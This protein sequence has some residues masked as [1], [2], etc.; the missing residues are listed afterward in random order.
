MASPARDSVM[1]RA[2]PLYVALLLALLTAVGL[3]ALARLEHVLLILFISV[4]F[5]AALSGPTER[6]EKVRIPRAVAVPLIY[7]TAL[8]VAVAIVWLVTPP[9][10]SEVSEFGEAAP[11]YVERYEAVRD[12]YEELRERYP[13]IGPFDQRVA[14]L[15]EAIVDRASDRAFQLPAALFALF[16]DLLSI[17]VISTLLVSNRERILAAILELV[18]P[19][20]RPK[21]RAVLVAMWTRIGFYL[22]AKVIV[23][24][25]VGALTYGVLLVIGVPF[26]LPLAIVVALGEAIPRAGPWLARIPLLAIAALEG[27]GTLGITFVASVVIENLKGYVISPVVEGDQLDIH[28]LVVFVSVLV[29]GALLGVAGAFIAVPAAAMVQVLYEEVFRPWRLAQLAD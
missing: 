21:T 25:I 2:I 15:G 26:A 14:R 17:F 8:V 3:I 27:L 24:T 1:H 11:G 22:R 9:L 16:L 7:L 19:N 18:H 6:L 4:L 10:F 5:A 12:A 29:G 13:A 23:M 20:H 28:P